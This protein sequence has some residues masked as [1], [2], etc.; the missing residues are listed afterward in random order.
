[1]HL[2]TNMQNLV[3]L[4]LTITLAI[5]APALAQDQQQDNGSL[6]SG[7]KPGSAFKPNDPAIKYGGD[8]HKWLQDM[9]DQGKITSGDPLKAGGLSDL[10]SPNQQA[11]TAQTTNPTPPTSPA[12]DDLNKSLGSI[13]ENYT[14]LHKWYKDDFVGNW[15][16]GIAHGDPLSLG[17]L[18]ALVAIIAGIVI[19][20]KSLSDKSK[21]T[22][23]DDKPTP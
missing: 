11:Q 14:G 12:N 1:M 20:S 8:S 17:I 21:A 2:L 5:T 9:K 7:T 15:F 6:N 4:Y 3:P 19:W 16:D 23:Q 10:R 13:N 22:K 18:A